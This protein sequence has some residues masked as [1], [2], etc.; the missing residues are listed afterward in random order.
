MT[1]SRTYLSDISI[2]VLIAVIHIYGKE[3][4]VTIRK[5]AELS[6]CSVASAHASLVHLKKHGLV[7]WQAGLSGTLRPLVSVH[8]VENLYKENE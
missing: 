4:R 6:G 3:R 2:R 1:L 8:T 7:E 5:A